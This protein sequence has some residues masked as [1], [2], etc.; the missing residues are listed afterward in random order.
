MN[1]EAIQPGNSTL[2][3]WLHDHFPHLR[4]DV[5]LKTMPEGA[6]LMFSSFPDGRHVQFVV[7]GMPVSAKAKKQDMTKKLVRLKGR[8]SA[9]Y[10][11]ESRA[12]YR[13]LSAKN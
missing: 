4:L 7:V 6:H 9:Q 13:R 12:S 5:I 3:P 11:W 1:K 2:W 8:S 10:N